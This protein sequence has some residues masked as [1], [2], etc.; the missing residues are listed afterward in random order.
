M[1]DFNWADYG[2][3]AVLGLSLII[4]LWRGF[5]REF[6]S[7]AT[8]VSAFVVAFYFTEEAA[9]ELTPWINIPSVRSILAFGALFLAT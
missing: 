2:V 5:L 9:V 1:S 4:G 6:I 3:L 7:L 8:W